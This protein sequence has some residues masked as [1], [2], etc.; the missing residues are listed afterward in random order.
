MTRSRLDRT[1]VSIRFFWPFGRLI[2]RYP[3][4]LASLSSVGIGLADYANPDTRLSLSAAIDLINESINITGDPALGL[5]AGE[6]VE[7]GDY[8]ALEYAARSC[9]NVREAIG[10]IA[11]HA[12][13]MS[14]AG[15]LTL[16][17]KGDRV[18]LGFCL[19]DVERVPPAINDFVVSIFMNLIRRY[20]GGGD[21][22]TEVQFVHRP[23]GYLDEYQR[24]FRT[25]VTFNAPYNAIVFPREWLDARLIRV[26]S[27]I[28]AAFELQVR[29]L[30]EKHQRKESIG[31][32]TRALVLAK[33]SHG[34]I[35]MKTVAR[36]LSMSVATLRRQLSEEKLR[37]YDIVE[38][39]RKELAQRYLRD[40]GR[41]VR[42]VAFLIGFADIVTFHKA[43]KRWTGITP[44][45]YRER[46]DESR[47]VVEKAAKQRSGA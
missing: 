37:Y 5:R 23:T 13:V 34:D 7:A 40:P 22:A 2:E 8:D 39:I 30:L 43:F 14:D 44:A 21:M 12:R 24:I 1:Q 3:Q 29:Q 11:R 31:D 15:Q 25:K 33:L 16:V 26:N 9:S 46:A 20:T 6:L 28:S 4:G 47:S 18:I 10:C 38:Q 17:E 36:A 42:D 32:K 19:V 35:S 27:R 45:Q 41:S